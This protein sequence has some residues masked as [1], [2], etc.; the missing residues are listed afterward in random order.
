MYAQV[1]NEGMHSWCIPKLVLAIYRSGLWS[2]LFDECGADGI[3]ETV[4]CATAQMYQKCQ[5]NKKERND[6]SIYA[7][8]VCLMLGVRVPWLVQIEVP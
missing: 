2:L 6:Y 3:G 7:S 1:S 5:K 4:Q 8:V